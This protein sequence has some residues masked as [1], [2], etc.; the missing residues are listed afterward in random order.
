MAIGVMT[1]AQPA[2][3]IYRRIGP[4]RMIFTGMLVS[5]LV[6]VALSTITLD[7]NLWLIRTLMLLRGLGF[8]CVLVP[9]QAATY[10]QIAPSET[11]RATALYNATSQFA[12]GLGVAVAATFLTS[13]L[14]SAGVSLGAPGGGINDAFQESFL[15]MG[16]IALVSIGVAL[17]IH[18]RDAAATMTPR[19]ITITGEE[20]TTAA[21]SA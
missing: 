11:G 14:S 3:R 13:R 12:S 10:A 17:L 8:G 9:L 21:R 4:R 19:E 18:D 6:T 2:S 7:T 20:P 1:I 16:V 15:F 5:A